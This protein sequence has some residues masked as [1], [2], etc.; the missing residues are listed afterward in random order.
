[1]L[2]NFFSNSPSQISFDI[3]ISSSGNSRALEDPL[4]FTVNLVDTGLLFGDFGLII[5]QRS[6]NIT[7]ADLDGKFCPN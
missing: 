3:V 4:D 2:R 6:V 7:V 1:M 5:F